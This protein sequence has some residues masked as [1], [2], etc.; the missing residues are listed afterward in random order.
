MD[1]PAFDTIRTLVIKRLYGELSET[2]TATLDRWVMENPSEA[3]IIQQLDNAEA[4][5][6][7][8][9][10]YQEADSALDRKLYSAIPGINIQQN[11]IAPKG[12]VKSFQ[13]WAWTAAAVLLMAI[14]AYLYT[15]NS[16]TKPVL[17]EK[18]AAPAQDILPGG[19]KAILTLSDG[20]TITLD[21][22]ANGAIARQ[23]NSFITKLGNGEVRYDPAGDP[24]GKVMMNTMTT[25]QGGQYKLILPDGTKVWLNAASS[26]TYPAVFT[27]SNRKVKITGEVYMEVVP[28]KLNPFFVDVDGKSLIQ[29]L[30]T[31][32]NINSY[33]DEGDIK[34]TLI[35]GAV[36]VNQQVVLKPG[37]QAVQQT[38][39]TG[40][41]LKI[42]DDVN[43]EQTLAWK[44]GVFSLSGKSFISFMKDIERWY[45][46]EVKYEGSIPSARMK[47]EMDR[48][49]KLPG[50]IRFIET[51]GYNVQLEGRKL[52]IK[53][54]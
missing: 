25:P 39:I 42:V 13:R 3:K 31:S 6:L 20:T 36:K 15:Y 52:V 48:G 34:T 28:G 46:I 7:L 45:N 32:F 35:K 9:Q 41:R 33:G 19:N 54:K 22:A 43:I 24:P 16:N 26:I 49:V 5:R 27:G 17:I 11:I 14:G 4:L 38:N 37:Q 53:A 18:T 2:E 1:Q 29:V 44:N 23:G 8:L 21:S 50:L 51:Y 47:G 12:R 30:G 10:H 40:Q